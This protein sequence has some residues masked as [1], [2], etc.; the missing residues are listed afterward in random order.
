M[1]DI[2]HK[3][4]GAWKKTNALRVKVA[5][6]WK[7]VPNAW[8]KVAGAWKLVYQSG[9]G[10]ISMGDIAK[11]VRF[12][13]A[14][15]GSMA[16]TFGAPTLQN[17][18][19]WSGWVKRGTL[20]TLQYLFS[21]ATNGIRFTTGNALELLI[22]NAIAFTSTAVF[23]DPTAWMHVHWRQNASGSELYANGVLLGS[24]VTVSTAINS[25]VAHNLGSL[26]AASYLSGYLARVC[27][28]DGQYLAPSDFAEANSEGTWVTK[29]QA[30]CKAI[31]DAGGANSFML[32]FDTAAALAD[33][34]NDF[35][36]KGNDW[37]VN[38]GISITAGSDYDWMADTPTNN[39]ALPNSLNSHA[40]TN[41]TVANALSKANLTQASASGANYGG[42][43]GGSIAVS[44]G[45]WYL[46]MLM[47][48]L[49]SGGIIT[50]GASQPN[51]SKTALNPLNVYLNSTN[52]GTASIFKDGVSVQSGLAAAVV[53][54]VLGLALDLDNLT[55]QFYL[56]GVAHG[57]PVTGLAAG[58]WQFLTGVK[59]TA[60]GANSTIS[61]NF[62]QRPF[63][64]AAPAGFV[65]LAAAA[66]PGD[67]IT[68]SG[69]FTG[70]ANAD[71]PFV[72]LG[73]APLT[74]TINGNAVTWGTHADKTAGGFKLRTALTTY[75]LSGTNN[76][77]VT[78]AGQR[79]K[80]AN[81]QANP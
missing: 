49:P 58:T 22:N 59:A 30:A 13:A 24:A 40:Q 10:G 55:A 56:N 62:G 71:G 60:G 41:A 77:T 39:H 42:Y 50:I 68:L 28:V 15:N 37:A 19:T 46:E 23:R 81:A 9:G 64:Y 44:A 7:D 51:T 70:N 48:T 74:M 72:W 6:V 3:A 26:A 16:R 8:V 33:L 63:A 47:D 66:D 35:S 65:P 75:N 61:N 45:K 29:S 14:T 20:S 80:Y 53:G 73:G 69:S 79:F 78:V 2:Y 21:C 12:R 11:A 25:A 76:F 38:A 34:G 67:A 1:P 5:G 36:A 27:F 52:A 17:T 32:D 18:F 54:G 43:Y 31:V 57:T 4:A